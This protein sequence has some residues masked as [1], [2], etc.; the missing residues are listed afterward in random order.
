MRSSPLPYLLSLLLHALFVCALLSWSSRLPLK[1]K[2]VE[3][4]IPVE[5]TSL[6][7]LK[8]KESSNAGK[9]S[10]D[11]VKKVKSKREKREVR[12]E[13]LR[14]EKAFKRK[15]I[16]RRKSQKT[17]RVKPAPRVVKREAKV[18]PRPQTSKPEE[19]LPVKSSPAGEVAKKGKPLDLGAPSKGTPSSKASPSQ[20]EVEASPEPKRKVVTFNPEDY[21][22]L[23]VA[24]L[25]RN[26][27]YPPLARRLGVE[28]VV[29]LEVTFDREGRPIEVR[30]LNSPPGIL[31]R[32]ALKL[33]KGSFYPPL[34]PTYPKEKLIIKLE[35]AYRLKD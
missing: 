22:K 24:V 3:V 4:S 5:L 8:A 21:K 18:K 27:F 14:K 6:P 15:R 31:K 9:S 28:G 30:V 12:K 25:R 10:K 2:P 29:K 7:P 1:S 33:V 17:S 13:K 26:K 19:S 35:I 23:V 20:R 11:E 16:V 34:P 32:A